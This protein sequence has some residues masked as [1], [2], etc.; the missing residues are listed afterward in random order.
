MDTSKEYAEEL[1]RQDPLSHFRN[2]FYIQE[3]TL[4]MDGNSLGLLSKR[5]EKSVF[6]ILD[7]WKQLGIDGWSKGEHPWYYL[8]EQLGE[9]VAG[10]IGG[11][12]DEVIVTGSTTVNLH[13]LASTFYQP[14]GNRTKILA[15]ELNF[16]SDIYALKSQLELKGYNPEDHFIQVTSRDGREI[17]EEDIIEAMTEDVALIVLPTVLYRSGQ[18]L[19]IKRLTDEAHKR[20]ILIGFDGC[21]SVGVVPHHF[22]EWDVD[23]AYWCHY[24]YVNSGP[25]GVGGLFVHERHLGQKPGLSGWF[26]SDKE[27]QFDMNHSFEPAQTAGAFQIGTP[28][29]LSVAPLIGSLELFHEA[30]IEQIREKSLTSTKYMMDLLQSKLEGYEFTIG[31]PMEDERRGGHVCLEH[32]EAARICKALK[33]KGVIPDFRSPNVIRLA[34]IAFYTSYVEVWETIQILE[35]IMEQKLY[36]KY[37]NKRGV[38][39]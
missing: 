7:S 33:D 29:L 14:K 11:E 32:K 37:E 27:K 5:A 35:D 38:I 16:P 3:G 34:P 8:S 30:G 22:H 1:D 10:L 25:G 39:A 28:H 2:E 20:G 18:L 26:G 17:K 9:Q 24:K 15:D 4:Y 13:Q 6:R 21:H 36:E 23:F 31:N 19:D 12:D